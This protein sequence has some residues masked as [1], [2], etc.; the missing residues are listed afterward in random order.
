MTNLPQPPY[1]IYGDRLRRVSLQ[2]VT[3]YFKVAWESYG[4]CKFYWQMVQPY[5]LIGAGYLGFSGNNRPVWES[6]V[7]SVRAKTF[8]FSSMPTPEEMLYNRVYDSVSHITCH[9]TLLPFAP[10]VP[11]M[12]INVTARGVELITGDAISEAVKTNVPHPY[13]TVSPMPND[14]TR[15]DWDSV[16]WGALPFAR[17]SFVNVDTL[18]RSIAVSTEGE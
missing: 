2:T 16:D 15:L 9:Y 5:D 7:D 18:W 8:D 10:D 1:T 14:P 11:R 17:E 12:V 4:V 13:T 6:Y 3:D